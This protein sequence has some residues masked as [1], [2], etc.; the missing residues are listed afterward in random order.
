[1]KYIPKKGYNNYR[2]VTRYR[3]KKKKMPNVKQVSYFTP[4]N[5]YSA[6]RYA[7]KGF[8]L[9]KGIINSELK[10]FTNN[11]SITPST[12]GTIAHLSSIAQGSDVD[13]RDGNSLLAKYISFNHQSLINASAVATVIRVIV[14][15]DTES[16][17]G[18]PPT[19]AQLLQSPNNTTSMLNS[20]YTQRFTVIFDDCI[21]LSINGNRIQN[22]KHYNSLNFH[23]K[24]TG[25]SGT[26]YDK[27]NIF[28]YHVSNEATNT[29]TFDYYYRIAFYDN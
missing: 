26:N 28:L 6:A 8:N 24:Y 16:T 7:V 15:I 13:G 3:R 5:M 2:S 14:F 21:D 4:R 1:M 10:R 23:I 22:M 25:T 11:N 9:L 18:S 12:T 19:A 29:P 20:D 17:G 27:N